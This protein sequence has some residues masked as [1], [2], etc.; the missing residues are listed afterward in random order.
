M[1][2]VVLLFFA[3]AFGLI[4][5]GAMSVWVT[6]LSSIIEGIVVVAIIVALA[7]L[8]KYFWPS[9]ERRLR[10][11]KVHRLRTDPTEKG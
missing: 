3:L 6:V 4:K 9:L 11:S 10:K 1:V 8:I 2:W 7:W 5:L